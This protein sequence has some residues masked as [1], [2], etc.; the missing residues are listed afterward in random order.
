MRDGYLVGM[1]VKRRPA[2]P[3]FAQA[4]G[5]VYGLPKERSAY[6]LMSTRAATGFPYQ[7]GAVR[8]CTP[9]A[10]AAALIPHDASPRRE[11]LVAEDNEGVGRDRVVEQLAA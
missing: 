8:S 1:E 6:G 2:V 5:P 9:P 3:A 4:R 11:V 7:M 10:K